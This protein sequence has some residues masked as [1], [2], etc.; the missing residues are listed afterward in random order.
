MIESSA[1]LSKY[2]IHSIQKL[3]VLIS[4]SEK[5]ILELEKKYLKNYLDRDYN[6]ER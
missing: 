3:F 2:I 5:D 4:K 6:K 1:R